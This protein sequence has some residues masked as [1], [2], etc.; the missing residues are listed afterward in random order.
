MPQHSS[1]HIGRDNK[2][3][4]LVP[5]GWFVMGTSEADVTDMIA[6][7]GWEPK[8]FAD[9]TPQHRV[10]LDAYFIDATPVT[11]VEYKRFIDA[12][13]N[14]P[15]PPDWDRLFRA[16]LA[17]KA[18]HPVVNVSWHDASAYARWAGKRLPTEAEWEKAARGVDGRR[19]AWGDQFDIAYCNCKPSKINSTT[20]VSQYAP[21][22]A[23]PYGALDMNGNVWEWCAD[24][25]GSWYYKIA[26]THNPL[27]PEAGDWRVLRG[28]AW[29]LE[30]SMA[31]C[32]SRD[33]VVPENGSA[34][35]GFRCVGA[36]R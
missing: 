31:R 26:P 1:T 27:G 18:E 2:R 20:P 12:N 3:M 17:G 16:F 5:A 32:A 11:N 36:V 29:D 8:W 7:F 4:V 21:Q 25:Y 10:Y 28:G 15:I 30:E 34:T 22:G 6:K 13:P 24:W 33:Y 23:S 14:H 35:V 9:E 19:Y